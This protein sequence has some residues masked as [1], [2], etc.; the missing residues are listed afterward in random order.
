MMIS[1]YNSQPLGLWKI[2]LSGFHRKY[3]GSDGILELILNWDGMYYI[4][5][6]SSEVTGDSLLLK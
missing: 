6:L 1:R 4:R 2:G 3:K 5:G